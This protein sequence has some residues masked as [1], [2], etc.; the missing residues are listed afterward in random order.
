MLNAWNTASVTFYSLNE[1]FITQ[2][3][4]LKKAFIN[5]LNT[6]S[7]RIIVNEYLQ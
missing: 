2:L 1:P 6:D 3:N 7:I 5:I 4:K